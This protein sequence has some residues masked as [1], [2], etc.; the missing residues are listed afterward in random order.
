MIEKPC[1]PKISATN[2]ECIEHM[3]KKTGAKLRRLLK[4]KQARS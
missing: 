3:Q 2:L 1:D 4:E